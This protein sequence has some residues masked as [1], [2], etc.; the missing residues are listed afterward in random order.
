M[1]LSNFKEITGYDLEGFFNDFVDFVNNDFQLIVNY[2]NGG[3]TPNKSFKE[4]DRLL[5]EA[6]KIES[7]WEIHNSRFN[8]VSYWEL[9]DKY[10]DIYGKLLTCKNM[11][12]WTRSSR[13]NS[14]DS[15]IKFSRGLK[16]FETFER[17][18][19]SVGSQDPQN[20][21]ADIA[22]NNLITEEDYTS[23]GGVIFSV[24]LQNNFNFDIPNIVDSLIGDNIYGKDIDKSF[25]FKDNDLSVVQ[26]EDA[27][28]QSLEIKL[29]TKKGDIPEFEEIGLEP[30][31]T[32]SNVN[33]I[34]YPTIFR[35]LLSS[36]QLDGRWSEINLLDLYREED[37]VFLK[38][39][40]KTVLKDNYVT[41]LKI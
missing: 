12:K 33:T 5:D 35:N 3:E 22:I 41:N 13:L 18:A 20:D 28:L 36:F 29:S 37:A 30:S 9:C 38:L 11:S 31:A 19:K 24:S 1:S 7:I 26:F 40:I 25:T 8:D 23:E 14:F 2:Y 10:T 27:L 32:S 17:V 21:W 34:Q 4:L 15:N 16:Q 39:E 6:H